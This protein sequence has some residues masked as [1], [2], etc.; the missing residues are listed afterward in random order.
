[1]L[2]LRPDDQHAARTVLLCLENTHN[3]CGGR[4]LSLQYLKRVQEWALSKVRDFQPAPLLSMFLTRHGLS[5]VIEWST[6][7]A[8]VAL[9]IRCHLG[10]YWLGCPRSACRLGMLG[11]VELEASFLSLD[12]CDECIGQDS[13]PPRRSIPGL[14]T[15]CF[16]AVGGSSVYRLA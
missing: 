13:L 8:V 4:V 12:K 14:T 16:I 2:G 3:R 7:N 10:V 6:M 15:C 1:M 5:F 9:D 11:R